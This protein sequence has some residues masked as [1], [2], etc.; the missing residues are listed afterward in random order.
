MQYRSSYWS[1]IPS[2]ALCECSGS[3]RPG[4]QALQPSLHTDL[5]QHVWCDGERGP[6][7]RVDTKEHQ[8]EQ[9]ASPDG[10]VTELSRSRERRRVNTGCVLHPPSPTGISLFSCRSHSHPSTALGFRPVAQV[11][12]TA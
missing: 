1:T 3:S 9:H 8:P 2:Q 6:D 7:G 10:Q 11:L 4:Q 5:P 12:E